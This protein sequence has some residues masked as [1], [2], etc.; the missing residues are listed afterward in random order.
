MSAVL[1][2]ERLGRWQPSS[3]DNEDELQSLVP[4]NL[5]RLKEELCKAGCFSAV[6][7]PLLRAMCI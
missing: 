1:K 7:L 3:N 2:V 6:L 5:D 4:K